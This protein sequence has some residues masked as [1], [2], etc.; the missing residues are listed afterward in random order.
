MFTDFVPDPELRYSLGWVFLGIMAF[1]VGV[2]FVILMKIMLSPIIFRI[3]RLCRKYILKNKL[4]KGALYD[5]VETST[6][7]T[8]ND[9]NIWPSTRLDTT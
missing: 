9:L 5:D 7:T 4:K 1:N 6:K 3:K 2:N 8:N